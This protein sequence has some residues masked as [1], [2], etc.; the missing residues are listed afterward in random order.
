MI[1]TPGRVSFIRKL[2]STGAT[3]YNFERS[4]S[5]NKI[6][7]IICIKIYKLSITSF[8]F[9]ECWQEYHAAK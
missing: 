5:F 3:R 1:Y 9:G 6:L 4:L 8:T 2:F 7:K